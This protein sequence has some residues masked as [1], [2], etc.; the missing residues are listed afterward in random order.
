VPDSD[1]Q[2]DDQN[3]Q[4]P[5][6]NPEDLAAIV[7]TM[8]GSTLSSAQHILPYNTIIHSILNHEG[9]QFFLDG[10][11]GTGK[12]FVYNCII[13]RINAKNI[14][15]SAC[16]STEIAATIINGCTRCTA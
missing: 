14:T 1:E 15:Y 6:S 9:K 8:A 10:P 12:S 2:Q 16:A 11:G 5:L 7:D 4:A 3:D 13:A